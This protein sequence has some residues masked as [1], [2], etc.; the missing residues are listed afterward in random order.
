MSEKSLPVAVLL[1]VVLFCATVALADCPAGDLT[2]DC[3]VDFEDFAIIG[4]QW[5]NGYDCNDVITLANQWLEE[6][7]VAEPCDMVWVWIDDPGVSDHEPFSGEM[8]KYETTNAQYCEFLNAAL[9]TGDIIVDGNNVAGANGSNNGDDFV[10]EPYYE[11]DGPGMNIDGVS[12]GGA[13][14]IDYGGGMFTVDDGFDDHPVTYVTL[15][16]SMAFCNYYGFRLPTEWEWQAVAD[17]DGS[18]NYGCG[19]GIN[20]TIANYDNSTHPDGTTVVGSFG[21][22]GYGMCDMAGNVWEWTPSCYYSGCIADWH[23]PRG[24]CWYCED[25]RCT[26]FRRNRGTPI[27][28]SGSLGFRVCR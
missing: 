24:G 4:A 14:R 13:A 23:V 22:Y 27:G 1:A 15:Y 21:A 16:G 17:Y 12:Y 11:L 9:A 28:A 19:T 8:S 6:G 3:V 10:G 26:V 25:F 5:L 7:I 20:T 18:F 2:D